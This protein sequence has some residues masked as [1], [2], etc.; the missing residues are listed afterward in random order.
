MEKD[1]SL[2]L[3]KEKSLLVIVDM[4]NGFVTSGALADPSIQAI[5]PNILDL[6]NQFLH[7]NQPVL[8]FQDAHPEDA[9]EFQS[10]PVHCVKGTEESELIKELLPYKDKMTCLEKNSTNGFFAYGFMDYLLQQ[11][12][13]DSIVITGCCTD[14]CVL[15][16]ALALKTHFNQNSISST[17]IVPKDCVDTFHTELHPKEDFNQF[18]LQLM[19]SSGIIVLEHLSVK[20]DSNE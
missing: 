3:Q 15:Q 8:A 1:I 19:E 20:E 6:L 18:S 7:F 16:F 17:I 2:D 14:I 11:G 12:P 9:L 5:T 10:F 13:F 4:V